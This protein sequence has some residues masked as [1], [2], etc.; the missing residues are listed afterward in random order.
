MMR[1]MLG[2]AMSFVLFL[3]LLILGSVTT[4]RAEKN[5]AEK[6]KPAATLDCKN[7][8][9]KA[10]K[11]KGKQ[12]RFFAY[13]VDKVKAAVVDG[14]K[15]IEFEVKEEK[16]NQMEAHHKRHMG[17]FVGSGGETLVVEFAEA[18]EGETAGTKVM[19]ETKKGFVGRAGQKSWTNAVLDQAEC[20]LKGAK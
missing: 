1:R 5:K 11:E 15:S 12:E 14:L 17:M 13:P 10:G 6:D 19:A 9:V 3:G 16:G 7:L 8:E 20:I 18:K 2:V 4:L